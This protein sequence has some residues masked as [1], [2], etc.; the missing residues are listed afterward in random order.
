MSSKNDPI[1][2]WWSEEQA[3]LGGYSTYTTP[4]GNTTRCSMVS[5]TNYHGTF[6]KDIIPL[7]VVCDFLE[8]YDA[9]GKLTSQS[10]LA[11]KKYGDRIVN[12]CEPARAAEFIEFTQFRGLTT[13]FVG[14]A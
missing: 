6:W 2:G 13:N 1:Y 11:R 10:N 3:K 8:H 14:R 12:T 9:N 5:P 7:G 4:E